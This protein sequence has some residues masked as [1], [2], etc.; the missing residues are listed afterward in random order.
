MY[1]TH[2]WS[3]MGRIENENSLPVIP[4]CLTLRGNR[5]GFHYNEIVDLGND[6]IFAKTF[7]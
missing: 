5:I 7:I 6:V 1:C 2:S 3:E 4:Q